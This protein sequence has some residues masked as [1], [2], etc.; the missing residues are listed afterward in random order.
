MRGIFGAGRGGP[1]L[2][3]ISQG[4]TIVSAPKIMVTPKNSPVIPDEAVQLPNRDHPDL[5]IKVIEA[6]RDIEWNTVPH[7][8][9]GISKLRLARA[10]SARPG[11]PDRPRLSVSL[12]GVRQPLPNRHHPCI[13]QPVH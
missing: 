5:P 3:G 6:K 13:A 7:Q 2:N 9:Q 4:I 8:E 10:C 12:C 11:R 1:L